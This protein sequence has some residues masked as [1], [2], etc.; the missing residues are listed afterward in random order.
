MVV[1]NLHL[2]QHFMLSNAAVSMHCKACIELAAL[3]IRTGIAEQH[4]RN[5]ATSTS[6]V[7]FFLCLCAAP[8]S[9]FLTSGSLCLQIIA[10]RTKLNK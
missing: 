10:Y 2:V 5:A 6:M 9:I 4:N 1:L 8:L 7:V 3:D